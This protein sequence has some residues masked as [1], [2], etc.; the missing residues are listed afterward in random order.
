MKS[1]ITEFKKLRTDKKIKIFWND[2]V[3]QFVRH[4]SE[5]TKNHE[6]YLFLGTYEDNYIHLVVNQKDEIY[7]AYYVVNKED[8]FCKKYKGS[9]Y[10]I[11]FRYSIKTIIINSWD[12]SYSIV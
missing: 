12:E 1:K 7:L 11:N 8:F 4:I 5:I 3:S 9:N 10:K 2:K 6:K